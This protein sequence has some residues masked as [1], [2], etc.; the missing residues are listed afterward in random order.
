MKAHLSSISS[1]EERGRNAL[2]ACGWAALLV[3]VVDLACRALLPSGFLLRIEALTRQ[4]VARTAAPDIDIV[5]DSV[6]RSGLLASG[7]SN[8]QFV[9]RNIAL[10]ASG[11]TSLTSLPIIPI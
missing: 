8:G 7:L 10:P 5:G 4:R 3:V 11:P 1:S 6:A 2:Q 9:A